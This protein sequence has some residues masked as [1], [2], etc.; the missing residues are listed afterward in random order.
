MNMIRKLGMIGVGLAAVVLF[1]AAQARSDSF[2]ATLDT[3]SLSGTQTLAF[4]LTDGDGVVDNTVTLSAF[5]FDSGGAVG[6]P[7][8]LTPGASGSL[9]S[10][11][12][13]DDSG[14]FTALFTQQFDPGSSL[15]FI[16]DTTNNFAG[17]TPDAFAMYVCNAGLTAC[18][19]DDLDTGALL[20][21]NMAGEALSTSSF[22]LNGASDQDLPAPIIAPS[23]STTSVGEPS[24]LLLLATGLAGCLLAIKVR[25]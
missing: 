11:I 6:V 25:R 2:S 16:F 10:G 23:S 22:I 20:V 4:A 1:T 21:L 3:S 17:G 7:D 14:G 15:K 9:T 24:S 13:L 18:Y 8:G 19:S 12:S 5:N